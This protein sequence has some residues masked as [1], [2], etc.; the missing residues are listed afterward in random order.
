MSTTAPDINNMNLRDEV[1]AGIDYNAD[2]EDFFKQELILDG[3]HQCVMTLGNDGVTITK[4]RDKQTGEKTGATFVQA[5]VMLKVDDP[6][7]PSNGLVCFD[8]L[9]T[10]VFGSKSNSALHA[11]M[12]LTGNEIPPGATFGAI[13]DHVKGVLAAPQRITVTTEWEAQVEDTTKAKGSR[14][15]YRVVVH[16]M[17]RFPKALNGDGQDTGKHDPEI[18]EP[19]TGLKASTQVRV[20]RYSRAK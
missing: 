14:E 5:H 13:E 6:Q 18:S 15:R 4:Q 20:L 3:D 17:A 11:V 10:I 16:G 9:S 1:P 7:D 8:R 12:K 2:P 19:G